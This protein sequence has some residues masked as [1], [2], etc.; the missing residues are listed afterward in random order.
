MGCNSGGSGAKQILLLEQAIVDGDVLAVKKI[1][2]SAHDVQ[3]LLT[4]R[5]KSDLMPLHVA[6]RARSSC[7]EVIK[8]I[9]VA[10]HD[11]LELLEARAH[12]GY[13][14][15][16]LAI[17]AN[18]P[19]AIRAF[20]SGTS[21]PERI[22]ELTDDTGATP[23][24]LAFMVG[25]PEVA[26]ALIMAG[27]D[28]KVKGGAG[29]L[30]GKGIW[31]A[32][33][34]GKVQELHNFSSH[35]FVSQLEADAASKLLPQGA[36]WKSSL[37]ETMTDQ[38]K[39]AQ[40]QVI[41]LDRS[42]QVA[43]HP[44]MPRHAPLVSVDAL[45]AAD[46][47]RHI[48]LIQAVQEDIASGVKAVLAAAPNC[49]HLLKAADSV[50]FTLLHTAAHKDSS[51]SIKAILNVAPDVPELLQI[52]TRAGD[53][54][55]H[56]ATRE[57]KL[58]AIQAL[59]DFMPTQDQSG[60]AFNPNDAL[61][62]RDNGGETPLLVAFSAC[63]PDAASTLI[64]AG[65]NV[66][67]K[68]PSG[69]DIW[70]LLAA[71]KNQGLHSYTSRDFI[72]LLNP[73]AAQKLLPAGAHWKADVKQQGEVLNPPT[74]PTAKVAPPQTPKTAPPHTPHRPADVHSDDNTQLHQAIH[75]CDAEGVANFLR[76]VPNAQTAL[77]ARDTSGF[78]PLH[79]AAGTS[80]EDVITAILNGASDPLELLQLGAL[81][82]RG[83]QGFTPLHVAA[84]EDN[85][86]AAQAMVY[87][88]GATI[89]ELRDD[90]GLT[91]LLLAFCLGSPDV[92]SVLISAGADLAAVAESGETAGKDIW[93]HLEWGCDRGIHNFTHGEFHDMLQA[94]AAS[95]LVPATPVR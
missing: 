21:H 30:E 61:E 68:T 18:H 67:A 42:G 90:N 69:N 83:Q 5:N 38:S 45:D 93:Q 25:R 65:A 19:E 8:S 70:R 47:A 92:A 22:L 48:R 1:L 53:T 87:H 74:R 78:T 80:S 84:R 59:L 31:K 35:A 57:N 32:F 3:H 89:M 51:A 85:A 23:L 40:D 64:I 49:Q 75:D 72:S 94:D 46:V 10:A 2:A 17:H 52:K 86:P 27:A 77:L 26:S 33:T 12:S 24:M 82:L 91:P 20:L 55:L 4:M 56:T 73:A 6:P 15:L 81:G 63:R 16:H 88:Q 11:T 95:R 60:H 37:R 66:S 14:P 13:T 28:V 34:V 43:A 36:R 62:L 39:V 41:D 9:L 76:R 44:D 79:V 71:G 50:G 54:P 29:N 58:Q 7:A